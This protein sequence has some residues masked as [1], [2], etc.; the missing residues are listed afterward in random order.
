MTAIFS[1]EN[2]LLRARKHPKM[3]MIDDHIPDREERTQLQLLLINLGKLPKVDLATARIR[4]ELFATRGIGIADAAHLA[5]SEQAM[6]DFISVD[7]QLLKKSS[8]L[9][10]PI[11]IGSPLVYCEKENLK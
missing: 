9:S 1:W 7:D 5:F 6:A 11:W 10:L 3:W 8:R 2:N 4:A